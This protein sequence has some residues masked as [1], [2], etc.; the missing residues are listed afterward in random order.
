MGSAARLGK[1]ALFTQC[2]FDFNGTWDAVNAAYIFLGGEGD[3][4]NEGGV[5]WGMA[6][7]Q[8]S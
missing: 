3:G 5:Q 2:S 4:L 7:F 1:G 8:P 6:I